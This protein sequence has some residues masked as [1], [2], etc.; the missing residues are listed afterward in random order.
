MVSNDIFKK[1]A[2]TIFLYK[3]IILGKI[4]MSVQR[5]IQ[6]KFLVICN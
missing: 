5:K 3:L 4:I 2:D 6:V 1:S